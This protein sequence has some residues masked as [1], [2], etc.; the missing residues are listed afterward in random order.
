MTDPADQAPAEPA[1]RPPGERPATAAGAGHRPPPAAIVKISNPVARLL[2]GHR[3]FPLWAI[4]HHRG[5]KSGKDYAIPVAVMATPDAFVI[6]LPW[7]V[8]TNWVQNVIAAGGATI[9]WKGRDHHVTDPR[10]VGPEVALAAAGGFQR[11]FLKRTRIPAFMQ[12][13]R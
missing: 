7:G 9:H 8:R 1:T 13:R 11:Y 6:G 2:A 5:R 10:I 3:W 12:L 4:L